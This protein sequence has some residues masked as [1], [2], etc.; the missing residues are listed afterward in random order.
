MKRAYYY[1]PLTIAILFGLAISAIASSPVVYGDNIPGCQ[2]TGS[3]TAKVILGG[4][5]ITPSTIL[6][7]ANG[8]PCGT[9]ETAINMVSLTRTVVVSPNGTPAQNGS[10]LLSAMNTISNASPS[11]ANPWLL[12]LEPGNYDM[13]SSALILKPYVDLEGSG[14]D[15]TLISS[16]VASS[17]F[18][19]A[20]GTLVMASNTEARFVKITNSGTG[21]YSTAILVGS[22]VSKARVTHVTTVVAGSGWSYGLIN[23]NGKFSVQE[24]SLSATGSTDS[25]GIHNNGSAASLTVEN[26]TLSSSG[27]SYSHGIINISGT[28]TIQNSSLTSATSAIAGETYGLYTSSGTITVQNSNLISNNGKAYG[29]YTEANSVVTIQGSALSGTG[30]ASVGFYSTNSNSLIQSSTLNG[31]GTSPLTNIGYGVANG[32]GT[33]KIGA[34]Q[35]SGTSGSAFGTVTCVA[36]YNASYAALSSSCT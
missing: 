36:S 2:G 29:F 30:F 7:T 15:T 4:R 17:S 19:P 20:Q 6:R 32:S 21:T 23:D 16:T 14:E 35:L 25:A 28:V 33:V 12:K 13:G 22:S 3:S 26:S 27:G 11:A 5:V 9:N 31:T 18:P 8:Q 1:A 10:A 24:S 34:S